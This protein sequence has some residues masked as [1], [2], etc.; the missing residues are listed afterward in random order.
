MGNY[1]GL[2]I[3]YQTIIYNQI[4]GLQGLKNL[5]LLTINRRLFYIKIMYSYNI[6]KCKKF[7]HLFFTYFSYYL[8]KEVGGVMYHSI[9]YYLYY[10][11]HVYILKINLVQK[12]FINYQP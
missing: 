8:F 5:N 4:Y 9:L 1:N 10:V 11:G 12:K 2:T 7:F 3:P 6:I